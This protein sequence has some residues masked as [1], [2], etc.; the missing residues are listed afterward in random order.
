M[1]LFKNK[2]D[3]KSGKVYSLLDETLEIM[4]CINDNGYCTGCMY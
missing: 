3:I 2:I 4:N 1:G